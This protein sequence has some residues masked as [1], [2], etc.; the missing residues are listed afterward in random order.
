MNK[1]KGDECIS[2]QQHEM[3]SCVSNL[4]SS[5]SAIAGNNFVAIK[6]GD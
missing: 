6:L 4:I 3:H 1:K 2:D 5:N